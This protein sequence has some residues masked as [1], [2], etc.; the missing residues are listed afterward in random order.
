MVMVLRVADGTFLAH[1]NNPRTLGMGPK[2]RDVDGKLF[3]QEMTASAVARGEAWVDYK[4][5]HPVTN[6]ILVKSTYVQR[7]GDIVVACG[8]YR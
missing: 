3:V 1:G 7:V 4:W 5:A 2:S 8:I 6:E